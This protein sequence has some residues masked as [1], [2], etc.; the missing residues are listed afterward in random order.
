LANAQSIDTATLGLPVAALTTHAGCDIKSNFDLQ[1]IIINTSLCGN[2]AGE[3]PVLDSSGCSVPENQTC[4]NTYVTGDLQPADY[5]Q[6]YFEIVSHRIFQTATAQTQVS[7]P[8]GPTEQTGPPSGGGSTTGGST[9]TRTTGGGSAPSGS[10]TSA[11][12]D[13]AMS[14][15]VVGSVLAVVL[16]A[17]AAMLS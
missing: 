13:A 17:A 16:T 2:F 14:V 12:G 15:G 1:K 6:A 10:N 8:G 7:A 11:P 5:A 4:Y 9:S 3:K